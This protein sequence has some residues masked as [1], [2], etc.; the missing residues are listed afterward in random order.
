M[1]R[2]P[3]N[4]PLEAVDEIVKSSILR[5]C[6]A[7]N[8]RKPEVIISAPHGLSLLARRTH[9]SACAKHAA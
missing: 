4:A 5:E 8:R 9:A 7:F 2:L 6:R 3:N 1:L